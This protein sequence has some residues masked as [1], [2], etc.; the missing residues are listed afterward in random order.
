MAKKKVVKKTKRRA[1]AAKASPVVPARRITTSRK[2]SIAELAGLLAEIAPATSRGPKSFC[3]KNL[4]DR[5]GHKK[6]WRDLSNKRKSIAHYLEIVFRKF[7][8]MPKKLVLEIVRGGVQWSAKRGVA[9][10]RDHL[11]NIARVLTDLGVDAKRDLSQ[12]ELPDPSKVAPPPFDLQGM[13]DRLDVHVSLKDDCVAMFKA[14]H[15]NESVRKALERFEKKVQD[16]TGD[17][18]IGKELMGK[19]FN[20][21]NPLISINSGTA[22]ND[23]SEQ[24]GFMHLTIG[25][26]AGMRN[27]Y[28]HG[29]VDTITPM[30]AFER[31]AFVSLL[32][33]RVDLA[34][35]V[36]SVAPDP[37][38]GDP[39]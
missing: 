19:A 20:R 2:S 6:L 11:T 3:V 4:A 16:L 5:R 21:Q 27:L 35:S 25:A 12:M 29:D 28:S 39:E 31:L 30:D 15:L 34:M 13:V 26:M 14:G 18:A 38:D 32:F 10:S 23:G 24:E 7:P 9:V 22:A 37:T 17:H 36:S 8:R 1:R 33:K